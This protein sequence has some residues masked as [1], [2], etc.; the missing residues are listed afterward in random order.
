MTAH[1][2]TEQEHRL[3]ITAESAD[4]MVQFANSAM[5]DW[6]RWMNR[7]E[8]FI[9]THEGIDAASAL[10][11]LNAARREYALAQSGYRELISL[12]VAAAE[13]SRQIIAQRDAALDELAARPDQAAMY[14]QLV[15]L[16]ASY[17]DLSADDARTAAYILFSPDE[18]V[19]ALDY[20]DG[21]D[22]LLRF[23]EGFQALVDELHTQKLERAES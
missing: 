17:G 13:A 22:A 21:L 14:D 15:A 1:L 2:E 20:V 10:A 12:I 6:S 18:D 19:M 7:I 8:R 4:F 5:I 23:R 11:D 16:L 9:S 3:R